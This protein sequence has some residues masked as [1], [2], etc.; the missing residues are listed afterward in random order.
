M[1]VASRKLTPG[2]FRARLRRLCPP[3]GRQSQ[4]FA[5]AV[6]GGADSLS[7]LVL[8]AQAKTDKLDF[9]V[10]TFDHKLRA[11]STAVAE[12]V[13]KTA[14][15]FGL[16]AHKLSRPGAKPKASLQSA[17]RAAR[18]DALLGWCAKNDAD[19]LIVA[20][21]LEDQAETFLLRLARGSGLDGLSAMQAVSEREN[22]VLIRPFLDVHQAELHAVL[23]G[24]KVIPFEDPS[25][26]DTRFQRV[27][28][29]RSKAA[30]DALG[31]T[32]MRLAETA[33]RLQKARH[34]LEALAA[35]QMAELIR[36]DACGVISGDKAGLQALPEDVALR[37]LRGLLATHRP[38]PPRQVAVDRLYQLIV[39]GET[40]RKT[41]AGQIVSVKKT[42]VEIYREPADIDATSQNLPKGKKIVWDQ[43]FE[44]MVSRKATGR[45]RVMPLGIDGLKWARET[46]VPLPKLPSKALHGLPCVKQVLNGKTPGKPVA[47]ARILT[48]PHI[49]FGVLP[50]KT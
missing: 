25:N 2:N 48:H 21:H 39:K 6:S 26:A 31:L 45:F 9:T 36:V 38:Y 49:S 23:R 19:G 8:A 16:A 40:G 47:V 35:D 34:V 33:D 30:F 10:L 17:A 42:V 20:H 12:T 27:A 28:F 41:L 3:A 32:S 46:G 22:S 1:R 37:V 14:E 44:I 5:L 11:G 7:L 18:Y 15:K 4:H 29:R 50:R 43:R 13:L 24:H